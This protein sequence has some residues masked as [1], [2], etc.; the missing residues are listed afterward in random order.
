MRHII[1]IALF[2]VCLT[3]CGK[4]DPDREDWIQLFNGKNL[5]GW[6]I[7]IA[8]SPLNVNYKNTFRV[9]NGVLQANYDEYQKFNGEYA[10]LFYKEKFSYYKIRVQYRFTGKQTP[11]G[12]G[13]AYRNSGIMLHGQSAAS[14]KTD[15]L[16]PT[17]IEFQLLGGSGTG[18]RPTGNL[19]TPGTNVVMH[20]S[21]YTPHSFNSS[22]K[23]YNGDQWVEAEAIVLGDSLITHLINEDTVLTYAKPQLDPREATYHEMLTQFGGN[24][25]TEGYISL[26]GESNPVEFR[27]VELLKL[28]GCMDPKALNYKSYYIKHDPDQ[29]RYK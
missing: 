9:K 11:G 21:L 25:L 22:S 17:S 2:L 6:D 14:M 19:C 26:Q 8:G 23:T 13:W 24:L 27:K 10:H 18:E 20:D 29:C 7:K 15:Q 12:A 4:N 5:K 3:G 1:S 16:F 28:K